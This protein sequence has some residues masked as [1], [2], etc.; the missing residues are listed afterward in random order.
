MTV[1]KH[2]LSPVAHYLSTHQSHL[3]SFRLVAANSNF[4]QSFAGRL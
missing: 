2:I 3:Q 4:L 1:M